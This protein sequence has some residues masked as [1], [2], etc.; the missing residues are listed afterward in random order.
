MHHT[1]SMTMS[2]RLDCGIV[3]LIVVIFWFYCENTSVILGANF[4]LILHHTLVLIYVV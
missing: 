4:I 1:T 2:I 3:M